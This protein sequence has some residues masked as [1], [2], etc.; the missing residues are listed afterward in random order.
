MAHPNAALLESTTKGFDALFSNDIVAA[1]K[2]FSGKDDPFHVLGLGVCA[3]L[4][5]ALGMEAGLMEEATRC[6]TAAELGSRKMAKAPKGRRRH[7]GLEW[8]IMNA[9]AVVLLGLTQA[10]SESYMGYLQCMYSLN[11]AHSKFTK[12]YKTVFPNGLEGH[13]TPGSLA[14]SRSNSSLKAAVSRSEAASSLSVASS[15]STTATTSTI[16]PPKSSPIRAGFFSRLTSG[17]T[18][19]TPSLLG[20]GVYTEKVEEEFFEEGPV[21]ELIVA[22][23][24]FG[25]GLFNL[26]FSLLPKKVQLLVGFLGFK[27]DRQLAL[28]ALAVSA[29]KDDVHGVFSGLVLMTYHGVVLLLSGYQ[30][31]EQRILREYKAIVDKV[32]K[33][34]PQGAL[35][36]LNR[37]KIL[38]MSHDAEG[39]IR[40]LEEGLKPE[41][42]HSFAQADT[43]LVF[44]LAWTLLSQRRYEEAANMFIK[45]TELNSWSHATYYFIAAGCH[46]SLGNMDKAQKLFDTIPDLIDKKKVGGKDLPTEVFIKKKL[47]FY[48]EK[49]ARRGASERMFV[50]SIGI[51]PA[52]EIGVFWNTHARVGTLIA[53]AHILDMSALTP[54]PTIV[55]PISRS[56]TPGFHDLDTPD[57]LALRSLL[58][59]INY[60]TAGEY[61]TARA[62]LTDAYEQYPRIKVSTWIGGVSMFE[63]AVLDLK[64]VESLERV[65]VSESSSGWTEALK[66]A[67]AKL[68]VAL[69][70]STSATDLSSRLD[71]RIAMLR[72]EITSKR[73]MLG[74]SSSA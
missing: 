70:L 63:L 41:R 66:N 17:I 4:E 25:F 12:L 67:S 13:I 29:A 55:I 8:E 60:R 19:S 21:E 27:H 32:D 5:A 26:V 23:T 49:Q 11:S 72:D 50:Q 3:F 10:L 40:V 46:I 22:G 58:L 37:A 43:L 54:P 71:S 18:S 7:E 52:E 24:A 68:D 57:E 48:K 15:A 2:H 61:L 62:F 34:Y 1:R 65:D 56:G 53:R 9:D 42:P 36:I 33:K 45:L 38:R 30:A 47:A 16:A 59:G 31:N 44:E 28:R 35:W 73:E 39:A 6:L 14:S 20:G 51:S 74:I 69:G 64:E